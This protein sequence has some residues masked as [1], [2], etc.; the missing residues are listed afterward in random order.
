[1]CSSDLGQLPVLAQ[2]PSQVGAGFRVLRGFTLGRG[3]G[4]FASFQ[5]IS[6]VDPVCWVS[7]A[8]DFSLPLPVVVIDG[9]YELTE[10]LQGNRPIVV[11]H[12]IFD[13]AG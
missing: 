10:I 12:L 3:L 8:C 2:F 4:S 9:L 11:Y 5:V 7:F 6:R 1:M 13:M